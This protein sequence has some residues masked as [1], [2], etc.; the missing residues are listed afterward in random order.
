MTYSN[1]TAE[2]RSLLDFGLRP[3]ISIIEDRLS[4]DDV[5]PRNQIVRFAI[6]DFLR[7]NPMERVDITI[8]L[9]DA[10]IIDVNE[11]RAMEDLAPRG[12]QPATDNGTTPPSDTR[13]IPTQ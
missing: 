10:G 3:Y 2:R 1:V 9:L 5:T 4:M 11:A 13:E 12:D 6:D 7:G 8:K